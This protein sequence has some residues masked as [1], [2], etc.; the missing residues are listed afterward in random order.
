MQRGVLFRGL[1]F[2]AVIAVSLALAGLLLVLRPRAE[3]QPPP[4]RPPLV[5]VRPVQTAPVTLTVEAFGTV[6]PREPL[7]LVAEVHGRIE[8]MA[9]AFTAGGWVSRN[10][11]LM[12]ID[13]RRYR[14]EVE[15]RQVQVEQIEA[16]IARLDQQVRNLDRS[17]QIAEADADLARAERDRVQTLSRRQVV[18]PAT[19][20]QAEQRYLA[21]LQRRQSL[22]N[23]KALTG[24]QRRQLVAGRDMARVALEQARL[25]LE[26]S[27]LSAPFDGWVLEKSVEQGQHVGTG[28]LLGRIYRA[29]RFDVPVDL[30][31]EDWS[32]LQTTT[33]GRITAAVRVL[34]DAF[35]GSP[36]EWAGRVARSEARVAA[37]TRT[38]PL[39]VEIDADDPP[40]DERSRLRPGMFV[41]V[42]MQGRTIDRAVSLPSERVQPDGVVLLARDG[43]LHRQP[44]T[45]IQRVGGRAVIGEGL[46]DGDRIIV[47]PVPGAKEG[48][49]LRT[50]AAG[51]APAGAPES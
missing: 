38:L 7:A 42:L 51:D 31:P 14:L 15:R 28:Q 21:S 3:R 29:G 45:V 19:R 20:D 6:A 30:P 5:T 10:M 12:R 33:D 25:D 11:V 22:A 46:T 17:L 16:E 9:P 40:D 49:A 37:D 13:P 36:L 39:V 35:Q 44:V 34:F 26:R 24:P 2:V 18:P 50:V 47:G 1:R 23:E 27:T 41:S 43:R 4:V 48:M 32:R 8:A